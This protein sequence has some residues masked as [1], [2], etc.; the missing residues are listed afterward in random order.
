MA[1]SPEAGTELEAGTLL[2][3]STGP[4]FT[5]PRETVTRPNGLARGVWEGPSWLFIVV[6]T[7]VVLI[8]LGFLVERIG[9]ARIRGFFRRTK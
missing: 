6:A 7:L 2:D 8:G 1:A 5:G 4:D 3:A 9:V